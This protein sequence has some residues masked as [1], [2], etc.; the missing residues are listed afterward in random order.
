MLKTF[1]EYKY[2]KFNPNRSNAKDVEEPFF[3]SDK[4]KYRNDWTFDNNNDSILKVRDI[5]RGL[6]INRTEN[7]SNKI[8]NSAII[9]VI[10][11]N[12]IGKTVKTKGLKVK[13]QFN[14]IAEQIPQTLAKYKLTYF[15]S[16]AN[17][18]AWNKWT[19]IP[20]E[21]WWIYTIKNCKLIQDYD[22]LMF[23]YDTDNN[24]YII[25][26]SVFFNAFKIKRKTG[27]IVSEVD[28]LGE[29]DWLS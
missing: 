2:I 15:T 5:I 28:P 13:K 27:K 24:I 3:N 20:P 26:S 12:L 4:K 25:N 11:N 6:G 8:I 29:E 22:H 18:N 17:Y 1:E 19:M 23:L 7:L 9:D 16:S 21:E 14:S 10:K